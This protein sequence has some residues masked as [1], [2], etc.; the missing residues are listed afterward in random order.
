MKT[1]VVPAQITSVEDRI[2]GNFTFAQIFLLII[3]LIVGTVIYVVVPERMHLSSLKLS[4]ILFQ[5]FILSGLALRVSGKIMAEWLAT[6]LRYSRRPRRYVF[7]KIDEA[8]R[9]KIPAVTEVKTAVVE[10]KKPKLA[11]PAVPLIHTNKVENLLA[12]PSVSVSFELAKKGGIDVS[13]T[14]VK[15]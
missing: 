5:F 3:A 1:T 6:Y 10:E 2:A 4:L 8:T 9:E 7:T 14:P 11:T 12:D 15:D 13:L